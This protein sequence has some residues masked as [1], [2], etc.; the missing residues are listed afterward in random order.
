MEINKSNNKTLLVVQLH[1]VARLHHRTVPIPLVPTT[2]FQEVI[3]G[4]TKTLPNR[5]LG[6]RDQW[7]LHLAL[8]D[9]YNSSN[10]SSNNNNSN[11]ITVGAK[12]LR[13]PPKNLRLL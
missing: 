10:N 4:V 1:L 8:M 12:V 6:V 9:D 13:M 7:I 2:T 11:M 3:M 5:N